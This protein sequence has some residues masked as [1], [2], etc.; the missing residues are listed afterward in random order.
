VI[1]SRLR[2]RSIEEF[3][4]ISSSARILDGSRANR[5]QSF[6]HVPLDFHTSLHC[7]AALQLLQPLQQRT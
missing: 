3:V 2:F 1:W 6:G 7:I 4:V 5:S